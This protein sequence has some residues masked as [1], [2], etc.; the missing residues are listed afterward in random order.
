MNAA[1]IG[2]QHLFAERGQVD[3]VVDAGAERLDPFELGRVAHHMVGHGRRETEQDV[4]VG[5]VGLY[6]GMVADHVDGQLRELFQQHGLVAGPH[7]FLDFG[8]DEEIWHGGG[9]IVTNRA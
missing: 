9:C 6:Q 8:E 7:R 3:D 2:D 4:G 5:D 1:D